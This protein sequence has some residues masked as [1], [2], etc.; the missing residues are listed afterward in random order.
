MPRR[1]RASRARARSRPIRAASRGWSVPRSIRLRSVSPGVWSYPYGGFFGG[2]IANSSNQGA[3]WGLSNYGPF[4]LEFDATAAAVPEI[5][6]ASCGS[7]LSLVFGALG[8]AERKRR[9]V[10]G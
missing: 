9:R 10:I 4:L 6:P 1:W 3:T 7:V 5:D 8:L 2:V